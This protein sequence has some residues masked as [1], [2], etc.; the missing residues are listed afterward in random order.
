MKQAVTEFLKDVGLYEEAKRFVSTDEQLA[1]TFV[2][3]FEGLS[4]LENY[5]GANMKGLDWFESEFVAQARDFGCKEMPNDLDRVLRDSPPGL[6]E[7]YSKFDKEDLPPCLESSE[8][9]T[10]K[11]WM[12]RQFLPECARGYIG[13]LVAGWYWVESEKRGAA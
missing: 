7:Y 2:R 6:R 5:G 12:T 8:L 4:I 11:D 13:R 9:D 3:D 1:E 10:C